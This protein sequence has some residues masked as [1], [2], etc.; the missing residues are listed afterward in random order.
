VYDDDVA[1]GAPK[2][3]HNGLQ[4]EMAGY[5]RQSEAEWLDPYSLAMIEGPAAEWVAEK[6][7]RYG[8]PLVYV[9]AAG[10]LRGERG[11]TTHWQTTLAWHA[12][13]HTDPGV[14]FPVRRLLH[15]AAGPVLPPPDPE[16][17]DVNRTAPDNRR[18]DLPNSRAPYFKWLSGVSPTTVRVLGYNGAQLVKVDSAEPY[19]VPWFDV[20]GLA[21]PV[22]GIIARP[23]GRV[24]LTCEDG[25]TIDVAA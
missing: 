1:Y 9:D 8:I 4:L 22:D 2:A 10:L 12:S 24:V 25:G 13:T 16:D 23:D 5:A 21:A 6:S 7:D 3:N 20:K 17:D 11:V 15:A 14:W 18:A 19:G